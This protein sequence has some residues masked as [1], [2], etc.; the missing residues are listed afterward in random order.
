VPPFIIFIVELR[1]VDLNEC[2]MRGPGCQ[3]LRVRKPRC[4]GDDKKES[5]CWRL[6]WGNLLRRKARFKHD[7]IVGN[8]PSI[9][10]RFERYFGISQQ[11]AGCTALMA[12]KGVSRA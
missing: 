10:Q 8:G 4:W 1:P 3:I 5:V 12:V 9:Q 2:P 6:H 11:L 7:L